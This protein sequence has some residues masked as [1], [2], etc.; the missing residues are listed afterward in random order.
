M[1][2]QRAGPIAFGHVGLQVADLERSRAYYRDV[3]GLVEIERS[4]RRDAYLQEVTGYPGVK[5]DIALFL[6]P[7]SN[8]LLELLEYVGVPRAAVD[9]STANPGTA[10]VCFQ[11]SDV[12]AVYDR[13]LAA[14]YRSVNRPVTPTSGRWAGGRSVY[15]LDPDAI[16]VELVQS[17][18]RDDDRTAGQAAVV[19][20]PAGVE[21]DQVFLVEAMFAADA[22]VRRRPYRLAHLRR[23]ANLKQR[24]VVIESGAYL[25]ALSTSIMLVRAASPEAA[26]QIAADDVYMAT[27][28]WE[29]VHV[30]PFGRIALSADPSG[31]E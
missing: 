8:V 10:H 13:A 31:S 12:D 18:D 5:L 4:I 28:V 26:R 16:R 19:E 25:D 9:T 22:A 30:R 17:V 7:Q 23:L 6:E 15:L 14:G 2:D 27:G 11:V 24:G 3:I 21:I 29:G 1:P 20:L